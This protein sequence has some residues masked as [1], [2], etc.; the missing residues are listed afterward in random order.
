MAIP[1]K[2]T[3]EELYR[4]CNPLEFSFNTTAE[5]DGPVKTTGQERAF[6]AI[7]FSMGI[8][9]NGFNLLHLDRMV[10]ANKVQLCTFSAI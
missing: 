3:P 4:I 9:Q 6:E 2:L 8:K 7:T 5:L 1:S 10:Q